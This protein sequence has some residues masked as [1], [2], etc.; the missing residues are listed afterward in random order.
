MI[1]FT[2]NFKDLIPMGFT[3]HKLFA[4]NYKVYERDDIWIWVAHGGYVEISDYYDNSVHIAKKFIDGTY[5][6][7]DED[8]DYKIFTIKKGKPRPCIMNKKTG[9]IFDMFEFFKKIGG[10]E[11]YFSLPDYSDYKEVSFSCETME[12]IKELAEKGMI[13]CR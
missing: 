1:K 4:N 2:G 12:T 5:P 9:E 7:Y 6:V 13:E 11:K 10:H 3:F 8:K